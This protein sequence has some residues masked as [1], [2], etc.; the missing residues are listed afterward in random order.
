AVVAAAPAAG[1][2]HVSSAAVTSQQSATAVFT[3]TLGGFAFLEDEGN[4]ARQLYILLMTVAQHQLEASMPCVRP[5]TNA[6]AV[7]AE[8]AATGDRIL[9]ALAGR[10]ASLAGATTGNNLL[11]ILNIPDGTAD[12]LVTDFT[13]GSVPK[14]I[15][16][17]PG[18]TLPGNTGTTVNFST[19]G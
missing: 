13:S 2:R 11:N 3:G 1:V 8:G 7:T 15:V 16:R 18:I 6:F 5:G 14:K 9:A 4:G 17:L 19:G 12:L 10:T